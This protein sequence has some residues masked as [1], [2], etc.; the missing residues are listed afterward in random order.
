[1]IESIVAVFEWI[2]FTIDMF[3]LTLLV[4]RGAHSAGTVGT[5]RC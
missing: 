5:L 3:G 2:A 4:G 1:M